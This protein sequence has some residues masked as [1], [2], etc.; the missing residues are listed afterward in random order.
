[1]RWVMYDASGVDR[2]GLIVDEDQIHGLHPDLSLVGLLRDGDERMHAAASE[3]ISDP[4]DVRPL[5]GAILRAPLQPPSIRDFVGFLDHLKNALRGRPLDGTWQERPGFYFSNV[6]AVIGPLEP[7]PVPP[8]SS[9]FDFE[10]EVGAV[11]GRGGSDLHPDTAAGHIAGYLIFCDWSARDLQLA[12]GPL[13]LGPAKGKDSANT[14]GPVFVSAD[15]LEPWRRGTSFHLEMEAWVNDARV[16][17]GYLDQMDWSFGELAAYASRG[18]RLV[19]GDVLGSGTVPT[20]C[21]LER[22][23]LDAEGFRGWLQPGDSVRLTVEQLGTLT[24]EIVESRSP[25]HALRRLG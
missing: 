16:G 7:V 2:L 20:G 14:L 4:H 24:Q 12:E 10:L 18:T 23:A 9:M 22:F 25:V 11:I 21:L 19:P 17:H 15:E 3:A 5:D 8:G 6:A 13:M 1:M